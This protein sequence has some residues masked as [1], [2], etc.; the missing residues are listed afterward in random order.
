M[1]VQA[2][3]VEVI[4]DV[5]NVTAI[6]QFSLNVGGVAGTAAKGLVNTKQLITSFDEAL[7]TFGNYDAYTHGGNHLTMVRAL[8]YWFNQ[9]GG[10][11][12]CVRAADGTETVARTP[13]YEGGPGE[14]STASGMTLAAVS[15]GSWGNEIQYKIASGASVNPIILYE[16]TGATAQLPYNPAADGSATATVTYDADGKWPNSERPYTVQ[17]SGSTPNQGY[18]DLDTSDG[19][20]RWNANDTPS[21]GDVVNIN[22]A[23]SGSDCA[24]I[25]MKWEDQ[26]ETFYSPDMIYLEKAL[27]GSHQGPSVLVSGRDYTQ[28]AGATG[29]TFAVVTNWTTLGGG[30][31]GAASAASD[32]NTALA[33]LDDEDVDIMFA[34]YKAQEDIDAILQT[35]VQQAAEYEKERIALCGVKIPTNRTITDYINASKDTSQTIADDGIIYAMPAPKMVDRNSRTS[36]ETAPAY[37]AAV[38]AGMIGE[39]QVNQPLTNKPAIGLD[40]LD[41]TLDKNSVGFILSARCTPF[42]KG[43]RGIVAASGVTSATITDIRK[44]IEVKRVL[45]YL[46]KVLRAIGDEYIGKLN[47]EDVRTAC[48]DAMRGSLEQAVLQ[49]FVRG[50]NRGPRVR[51][52]TTSTDEV[53][54]VAR[55]TAS[56]VPIPGIEYIKIPL[57]FRK[58]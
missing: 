4:P 42:K 43:P 16:N 10:A 11:V 3:G 26:S 46:T 27:T 51:D 19:T 7:S 29:N 17:Y 44:K 14:G 20:V 32:Y 41:V 58:D 56:I 2:P 55:F 36:I 39:Y 8:E 34:P 1:T 28:G 15:P 24:K 45:L 33:E 6:P 37:M 54:G 40:D 25:D 50:G 57:V 5:R 18:V 53:S 12:W 30:S 52:D 49:K 38:L 47:D 48:M 13:L 31:N 23:V 21:S 35:R 22:Y 9:G